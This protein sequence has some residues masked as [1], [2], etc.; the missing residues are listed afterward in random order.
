MQH[1]SGK[2][3]IVTGASQGLGPVI[4][5][6]LA[7]AGMRLVLAARNAD[8]LAAVAASLEAGGADVR[9]VTTDLLDDDAR[10]NLLRRALAEFGSVDVLINNAGIEEIT[11]FHNQ[12]IDWISRAV[13]TNL[14]VPML[15]TRAVLPDM[16]ERRSGHI[17][18]IASLAGLTTM[19]YGAVYSGTKAGLAAWSVSL[20][21]EMREFGVGV[22]V[23]CPGFVAETGMFARKQ[24]KPPVTVGEC[25]PD[26]V[27][28]AV[29]K[30][31]ERDL[32][33]VIVSG[34]P[35]RPFLMLRAVA[36]HTAAALGRRMGLVKFL[37]SLVGR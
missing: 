4:A 35:M 2:T 27:G 21:E 18:N 12:D 36:P 19:P 26:E 33:E 9:A 24:S 15:L 11:E 37:R 29:V 20:S 31:L 32:A 30:A 22:S 13:A 25:T 7:A 8:K 16:V 3:A 23:I 5:Q 10:R 17:V 34:R 14:T 28:D 6:K 1:L